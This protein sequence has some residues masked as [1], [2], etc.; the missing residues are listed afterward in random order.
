MR[1]DTAGRW[2]EIRPRI[3]GRRLPFPPVQRTFKRTAYARDFGVARSAHMKGR[4]ARTVLAVAL[5]LALVSPAHAFRCGNRIITRGD[6][7]DKILKF[8]GEPMSVQTRLTQRG[9]VTRY[10][11]Y[12]PN[13]IEEV[14]VEEWTYNF[15]PHQL[16]RIVRLEN[17][18]VADIKYLGYGH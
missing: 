6:H 3:I 8:C 17:G 16:M 13:L 9:F 5:A 2:L 4:G 1:L 7:A 18:L 11:Q 10:G 15:G 12:Y 14:I